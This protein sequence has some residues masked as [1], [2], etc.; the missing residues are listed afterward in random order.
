LGIFPKYSSGENKKYLKPPP[1]NH[2]KTIQP[3]LGPRGRAHPPVGPRVDKSPLIDLTEFASITSGMKE[4]C[5]AAASTITP[6]KRGNL[7]NNF[8]HVGVPQLGNGHVECIMY[9][10]KKSNFQVALQAANIPR[11]LAK[12]VEVDGQSSAIGAP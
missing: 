5:F 12:L 7:T 6:L 4:D 2:G 11:H 9:L 10:G 1:K 3:T 8:M